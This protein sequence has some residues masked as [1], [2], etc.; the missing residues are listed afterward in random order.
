VTRPY[1]DHRNDQKVK[2]GQAHE[3]LKQEL[4]QE[5]KHVVLGGEDLVALELERGRV[6]PFGLVELD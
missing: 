6:L 3:L 1:L 5:R 2:V 4:W